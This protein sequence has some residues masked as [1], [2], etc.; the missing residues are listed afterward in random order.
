MKKIKIGLFGRIIIGIL[1][2]VV[3]GFVFAHLGG[4][5]E[6]CV[7][8]FKTFNVLFGQ[9]LK[10]IGHGSRLAPVFHR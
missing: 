8:I 9:L 6:V 5:G 3:L 2:G 7:R 4:V 1:C 10:F